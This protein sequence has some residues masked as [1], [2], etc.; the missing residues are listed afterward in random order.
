MRLYG[1][2]MEYFTPDT[3]VPA[4]GFLLVLTVTTLVHEMGHLF[5]AFMLKIPVRQISIGLGPIVWQCQT[6]TELKF[7][8]RALPVGVTVGVPARRRKDGELRR[9]PSHDLWMAA[10]GP[11]ANLLLFVALAVAAS[12]VRSSFPS[13][14]SWFRA[15]A[16]LSAFLGL[17]NLLPV[18]G[19]DGGHM[20]LLGAACLG[21][22]VSQERETLLHRAG[23]WL[24]AGLS[25][26]AACARLLHLS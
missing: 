7:L 19:L 4:L 6:H 24:M 18:P 23:L 12:A 17:S 21:F 10:A 25:L 9:P 26:F 3:A 22:Q 8:L 1:G 13:L 15:I 14:L 11:A 16:V 20:L 2:D 5:A